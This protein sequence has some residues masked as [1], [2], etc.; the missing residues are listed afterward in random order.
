MLSVA[1]AGKDPMSIS[2]SKVTLGCP[3]SNG[4]VRADDIEIAPLLNVWNGIGVEQVIT[5]SE[6]T[7]KVPDVIPPAATPLITAAKSIRNCCRPI[8]GG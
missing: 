4:S 6:H 2:A 8:T 3:P 7:F 5:V 1:P